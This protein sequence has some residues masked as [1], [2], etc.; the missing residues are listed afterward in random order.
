MAL[1]KTPKAA[2]IGSIKALNG[3]VT[4]IESEY[5]FG[6]PTPVTPASDGTNTTILISAKDAASTFDGSVTVRYTRL[7]LA[8]L[9][10]L[11]PSNLSLPSVTTVWEFA[12]AFNKTYGTAFE[13]GDLVDGPLNLTNG[14]GVV[15]LTAQANSYGWTGTVQFTVEPGRYQMNQL[16]TVTTLPGLNFPDP[17]EG[18]PFGWAYSYWRNFSPVEPA[19]TSIIPES[20]DW[21]TIAQALTTLTNDQWVTSGQ[22]RFSLSGATLEYNGLTT[23]TEQSNSDY[24]SVMIIRLG[25]DCLG[26]SG[27]LFLHYTP[28]ETDI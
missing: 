24:E 18:K 17:Y 16:V 4:L 10:K 14:S 8:D 22:N 19:L 20:V 2:I 23:G 11:V 25:A 6:N 26:F 27:R 5:V 12:Q 15:T 28:A 7:D 3:G 13:Q 9:L 21:A 1:Y